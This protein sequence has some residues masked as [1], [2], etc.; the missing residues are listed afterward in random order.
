MKSS[1]L[2]GLSS[3]AIW[4]FGANIMRDE[5]GFSVDDGAI[6]W[7]VLGTIGIAASIAGATVQLF[8][9]QSVRRFSLACMSLALATLAAA[10]AYPPLA[11]IALG[12]FGAA[13]IAS[14][15]VLLLWGIS[16]YPK[17]PALGLGAP[18]LVVALGQTAGAPIFGLVWDT[19]GSVLALLIFAALIAS[20]S[21]FTA[22]KKPC[23]D[24]K[25]QI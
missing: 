20:G 23:V 18:F 17:Q 16:I 12:L 7:V 10:S 9:L 13:Y 8:G 24:E 14:T 2:V 11:Y 3:T 4:T 15:G 6:G 5:L 19:G 21:S 22:L 1:F 25:P